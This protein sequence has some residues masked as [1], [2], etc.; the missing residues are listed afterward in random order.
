MALPLVGTIA[1][2]PQTSLAVASILSKIG[3]GMLANR[4]LKKAQKKQDQNIANANLINSFGGN[5]RPSPVS[6]TPGKGTTLLSLLGTAADA[7][8][9]IYGAR[10][11]D[12]MADLQM[13]ALER[14]KNEAEGFDAGLKGRNVVQTLGALAPNFKQSNPDADFGTFGLGG[15]SLEDAMVL[16]GTETVATATRDTSTPT[17]YAAGAAMAADLLRKRDREDQV[18]Y[19]ALETHNMDQDLDAARMELVKAQ[20]EAIRNKP[21]P[22]RS[23]RSGDVEK[24]NKRIG[25]IDALGTLYESWKTLQQ[26]GNVGPSSMVTRYMGSDE[27]VRAIEAFETARTLV[28]RQLAMSLNSGALSQADVD[29]ITDAMPSRTAWRDAGS[30][31]RF[32]AMVLRQFGEA[33]QIRNGF[34]DGGYDL[35]PLPNPNITPFA[36]LFFSQEEL[37]AEKARRQGR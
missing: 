25:A 28:E 27:S 33:Q 15:N 24:Y 8:G 35:S 2:N 21:M 22:T 19:R 37:Q 32:E 1:A 16:P 11:A 23:L 13:G 29:A 6:V 17:G 18:E 34:A 3:A 12:K 14:T 10:R 7:G 20:T 30:L 9:A 31:G 26:Q 36:D 4:D 5:A